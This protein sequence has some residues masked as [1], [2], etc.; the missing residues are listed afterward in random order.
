[1]SEEAFLDKI[2][3]LSN[4]KLRGSIGVT[5]NQSIPN[6]TSQGLYTPNANYGGSGVAP[7]NIPVPDLSWEKTTQYDAGIDIA[8]FNDRISITSDIYEKRTSD[9]LL[10][11][12][13][14]AIS[15]FTSTLINIGEVRNRGFE[16]EL[17]TKNL[18]GKLKWNSSFNIG[19]NRNKILKLNS[20][21]DDIIQSYSV[22]AFGV[23][24]S[25]PI[26]IGR[27]GESLGTLYGYR[28]L[29]VFATNQEVVDAGLT[30][31]IAGTPFQAGDARFADINGDKII[32]E[33]DR[34]KIGLGIP[35]FQG[36][37]D[38]S[39]SFKNYD[40]GVLVQF[41]YGN[42][43]YNSTR[44]FLDGMNNLNRSTTDVLDRW[45]YEGDQ[46]NV[47]RAVSG[48]PVRNTRVS[49]RW[50]EDGSYLRIKTVTLG[51]NIP[52][53]WSKKARLKTARLYLR[54]QNLLTF[55]KYSGLDPEVNFIGSPL[56]SGIDYGTFPQARTYTFG[57]NVGF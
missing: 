33:N 54:G 25:T 5:G 2:E 11:N 32:N 46:T 30:N 51:Y 52:A 43:L 31:G 22:N 18:T 50:I 49:D 26:G 9:L 3:W 41:S 27:V 23:D 20:T 36:G 6:F 16:L 40:L 55:T 19:V 15:G 4:L 10:N 45:R 39:F 24:S 17:S 14:P 34:V 13:L 1:V 44:S 57:L 29:G 8:L 28:Y 12:P 47:A 42:E 21:N 35:K 7:I 48:D 38:N 53:A 37:F 56:Q